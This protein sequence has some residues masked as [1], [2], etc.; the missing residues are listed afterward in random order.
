VDNVASVNSFLRGQ[1]LEHV[2]RTDEAVLL[3]ERAVAAAFDA[4]GP[5]DRL[6]AIYV[7]RARHADV[8]RIA[9]AALVHVRTHEQKRAWYERAR[10]E[11]RKARTRLPQA[12]PKRVR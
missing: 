11:A 12:A 7:N 10:A 6:I 2:G 5:Y 3:Y 8:E 4:A 9:G 1:N